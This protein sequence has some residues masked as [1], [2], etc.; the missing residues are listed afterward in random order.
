[1]VKIRGPQTIAPPPVFVN[2]M[3]WEEGHAHLYMECL[4]CYHCRAKSLQQRPYGSRRGKHHELALY[5]D[6]LSL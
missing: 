1:M 6:I 2:E 3:L 5:R 4:S